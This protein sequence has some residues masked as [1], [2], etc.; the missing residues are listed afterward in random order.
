MAGQGWQQVLRTQAGWL[1]LVAALVVA[2]VFSA[3][4]GSS[5]YAFLTSA[6]RSS[7]VAL[8]LGVSRASLHMGHV[9]RVFARHDSIRADI[10]AGGGLAQRLSV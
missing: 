9:R 8:L 6:A 5:G 1:A 3:L 4:T 10:A 2:L 7:A